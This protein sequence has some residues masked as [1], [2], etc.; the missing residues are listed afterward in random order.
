[1]ANWGFARNYLK[2]LE[3]KQ[4][5]HEEITLGLP[6][7]IEGS[8]TFITKDLY[9]TLI[10]KDIVFTH[11]HLQTLFSLF[12]KLVS[13]LIIE[14]G[15]GESYNTS[16]FTIIEKVLK[17]INPFDTFSFPISDPEID[18][19]RLAKET[20]NCYVHNASNIDQKWLNAYEN[21]HGSI[22]SFN[23]G[24]ELGLMFHE[25]EIWHRLILNISRTLKNYM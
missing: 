14:K 2:P 10:S 4:I 18:E 21:V 7:S 23:V 16:R 22:N 12:K 1:M 13:E 24:D 3:S 9:K 11:G 19:L 15:F 6:A 20:R 25:V 17:G 8:F 5:W